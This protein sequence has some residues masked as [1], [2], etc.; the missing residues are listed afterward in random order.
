MPPSRSQP[1]SE[2]KVGSLEHAREHL[3]TPEPPET[4][5]DHPLLAGAARGKL[6]HRWQGGGG[7]TG[8]SGFGWWHLRLA[9]AF[10]MVAAA[11]FVLSAGIAGYIFLAGSNSVSMDKISIEALGPTTTAGGDI[12]SF[13]VVVT[14]RNSA[15]IERAVL[16]I[17]FPNGTRSADNILE[18]YPRY[19]EELGT[20]ESGESVSRTVR[21]VVFGGAGQSLSMPITLFYG[22]ASSN[23]TFIKNSSYTLAVS[24]TP[25]S[26]SID[27]LS[28]TVSGEPLTLTLSVNSNATIPLEN[29]VLVSTFPFGFEVTSSSPTMRNGSFLIGTLKPGDRRIVTLTGVLTGQDSEERIFRFTVGTSKTARDETLAVSYMTQDASVTIAAPFITTTLAVNGDT[30]PTAVLAP[31]A[32]HTVSVSYANTLSTSI[33]DAK[34]IVAISGAP[35]D[36]GSVSSSNGFYSSVDRAV[37][38]SKDSD[39][40][41]ALLAPGA[42]GVGT[43]TFRTLPTSAAISAPTVTFTTSVSGT[44]VGQANVP[45][46]VSSSAI[47]T[48]RVATSVI[49]SALSFHTSGPIGNSGPVPPRVDERT[50][51]TV[52]WDLQ[53]KGNTVAGGIV[54]A[55]LPSYVTYSGL[56]AGSGS[57][58]YNDASHTVSW[59]TGDLVQGASVRGYF[60]VALTPSISQKGDSP[61]LTREVSFSGYDRFAGVQVSAT[62]DP[63][64]TETRGDP[65]FSLADA[66][67]Q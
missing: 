21:A 5:H 32:S 7:V 4:P 56:T 57:F 48:A 45:R 61:P 2:E 55:A 49:L 67:V 36:Y 47:K 23:A 18:E 24:T 43:I 31:N 59:N 63:A 12:V 52:A 65:N 62:V 25:L 13:S 27:T 17:D 33:A 53:N 1:S 26:V 40:T 38:F 28:E 3:Y 39:S 44:R 16:E 46:Q 9:R 22:A 19:I 15:A 51:Y 8:D 37:V 10:F 20:L 58:S 54:S 60:Q 41:L 42:S 66:S 14:N 64:T 30:S 35:V 29:V 34:I 6:P 50:T 11:F